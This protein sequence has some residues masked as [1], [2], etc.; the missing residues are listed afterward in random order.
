MSKSFNEIQEKERKEKETKKNKRRAAWLPFQKYWL[1]YLALI[2]T[3]ILSAFAGVYI[4]FAPDSTGSIHYEN[5]FDLIRRVF[6]ALFY[7]IGFV[8]TAEGATLYWESKLIFHDVNAEGKT[9][10]TQI[11]TARI[12]LIVSIATIIATG[13]ASARFLTTWLGSLTAFATV[14]LGAQEWVVWSIPILLVFH[15]ITSI[16][17]WY[18]SEEARLERWQSDIQRQTK[19]SNAQIKSDA[20]KLT[21]ESVAPELARQQGIALAQKM[22]KQDFYEQELAEGKDLDGDGF[23]GSPARFPQPAPRRAPQVIPRDFDVPH[24]ELAD[25]NTDIPND[26]PAEPSF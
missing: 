19:A 7:M 16:L 23:V 18:N 4:G 10:D 14:P 13:L 5:T 2:F 1:L 12:A 6:F 9:N 17:Y 25:Q 22:L 11:K 20:W 8:A 26:D 15:V 3:A 24:D 21:Y